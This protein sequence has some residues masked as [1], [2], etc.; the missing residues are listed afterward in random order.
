MPDLRRRL[1]VAVLIAT[2]LS[3][4]TVPIATAADNFIW[5]TSGSITQRY[6]CTGFWAEPRHGSCA[7]FHNGTDIANRRGTPVRAAADGVISHVGWDPWLARASASWLVIINHGGGVQTMYA[8]LRARQ[9]D[10]IAR[11]ERVAQGD[12]IG[13]MDTTGL[14]TGPHLHFSFLKEGTWADPRDYLA[15]RPAPRQR[16]PRPDDRA[17]TCPI[18]AAGMGAW[19]GGRTALALEFD[20][21]DSCAA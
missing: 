9:I 6:G 17:T 14:S 13:L 12:V 4:F 2:A 20:A 10:G 18:V 1:V 21:R 16:K 11:G 15:G 7:H 19:L 3:T 8:H 5:P